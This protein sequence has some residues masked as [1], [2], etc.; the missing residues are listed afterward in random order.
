MPWQSQVSSIS[1]SGGERNVPESLAIK[2]MDEQI[3]FGWRGD[4]ELASYVISK[5]KLPASRVGFITLPFT[6]LWDLI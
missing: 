2:Q 3:G 1:I 6:V 4:N 5:Y